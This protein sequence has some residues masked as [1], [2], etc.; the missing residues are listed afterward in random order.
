MKTPLTG[1]GE[2]KTDG[3]QLLDGAVESPSC[4]GR[5]YLWISC[6]ETRMFRTFLNVLTFKTDILLLSLHSIML[7]YF[8]HSSVLIRKYLIY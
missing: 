6:W 5:T 1:K 4:P 2:R 8:L 7:F 3:S